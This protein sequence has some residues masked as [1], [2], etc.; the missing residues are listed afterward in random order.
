MP[1]DTA[2]T[3][4]AVLH[5]RLVDQ[6]VDADHVR[7]AGV[8]AAMRAVPRHMFLPGT[9]LDDAYAD[10][11][12]VTHRDR[13]GAALSSASQPSIIA[14]MLEQLDPQPG[15]QVL[16]IGAGTGYQAA[17]LHELVGPG[18]AVTTIDIDPEVA[19]EARERLAAA[20]HPDVH[21]IIDDG[22]LGHQPHAPYDRIIATTGTWDI[23]PAWWGQLAAGG[24]VVLPLR[25]RG[26]TRSIAFD[27]QP[28]RLVSRSVRLCGFIPMQGDNG[29]ITLPLDDVGSVT[30]HHD[31][32]QPVKPDALR[33]ILDQPR[34]EV[35]SGIAVAGNQPI[36]GIWLRLTTT[37]P[38]T[39]RI[40]A[41]RQ[42]VDS[43]L[44]TPVIPARSPAIVDGTSLAYLTMRPH[45]DPSSRKRTIE[46]GA[47]GHGPHGHRLADRITTATRLWD[48]N[49]NAEPVITA[50]PTA[51]AG[52]HTGYVI[53]KRHTRLEFQW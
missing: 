9:G 7:T 44:A 1:T 4:A 17:L 19:A 2:P 33:G 48:Q 11:Y 46:L 39:C 49:R 52:G 16:E 23:Y 14:M 3:R 8:E 24:R 32:D 13:D 43:G 53:D 42:A 47:A 22:A 12:V 5:T 18:G 15:Q 34:S 41:S 29:E 6:L 27:H 31:R 30:C 26:Q 25:W 20:G 45:H 28:G 36:D 40:A 50:Y 10:E 37:E 38:G 35:W 21:V 51:G